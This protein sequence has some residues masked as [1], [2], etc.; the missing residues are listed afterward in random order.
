MFL[1][2]FLLTSA[3]TQQAFAQEKEE[4]HYVAT[5]LKNHTTSHVFIRIS[6]Y[7]VDVF[8]KQTSAS[9]PSAEWGTRKVTHT[10]DELI[11]YT[12]SSNYSFEITFDNYCS[13]IMYLRNVTSN[14]SKRKFVLVK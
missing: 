12:T 6:G 3:V 2:T 7:Q 11:K 8:A 5:N 4:R 9:N 13:D 14:T 1:C 10:S